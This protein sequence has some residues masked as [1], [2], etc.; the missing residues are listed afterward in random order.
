ML[1]KTFS[2]L[3]PDNQN[4]DDEF[5]RF[6]PRG[7]IRATQEIDCRECVDFLPLNHGDVVYVCNVYDG[8]TVTLAWVNEI[9]VKVKISCRIEGIDTPE[10]RSNSVDE[11]ALALAAKKRLSDAVAGQFVSII[12][13]DREKYGRVLCDLSTKRYV[14]VKDY[15]LQDG[16]ICRPYDGGKKSSWE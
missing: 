8:D 3:F 6:P 16:T 13:P 14:S 4:D 1:S 12:R 2:Y 5:I 7:L 9:G 10:L 15:M 11:K